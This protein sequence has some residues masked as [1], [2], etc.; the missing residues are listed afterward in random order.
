M[1]DPLRGLGTEAVVH[2][3]INFQ[4]KTR[5]QSRRIGTKESECVEVQQKHLMSSA[6][7]VVE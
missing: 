4:R 2:R 1:K 3:S 7:A 6:N 5:A